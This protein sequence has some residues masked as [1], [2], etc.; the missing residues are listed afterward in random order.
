MANCQNCGSHVSNDFVRVF[1]IDGD[2]HGCP[3]CR[4]FRDLQEAQKDER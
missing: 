2:V 3:S 1:G 4:T